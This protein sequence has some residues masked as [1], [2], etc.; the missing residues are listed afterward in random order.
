MGMMQRQPLSQIQIM[1]NS[2]TVPIEFFNVSKCFAP[3]LP[4][5]YELEVK[6]LVLTNTVGDHYE[7]VDIPPATLTID[8]PASQGNG[9]WA[10][11]ALDVLGLLLCAAG[12]F[13]LY[14]RLRSRRSK[15]TCALANEVGSC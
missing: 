1:P 6:V 12:V 9:G 10:E 13:W 5:R 3:K 15:L 8:L 7:P 14:K 4:G 2:A 11:P